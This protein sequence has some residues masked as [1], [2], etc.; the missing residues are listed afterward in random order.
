MGWGDESK[1]TACMQQEEGVSNSCASCFGS[2]IHCTASKCMGK[3]MFGKTPACKACAETNCV[4][5][6]KTCSGITPPSITLQLSATDACTNDA[7][8][9][10]LSSK[11][12][13]GIEADLGACGR[14]SWGDE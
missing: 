6:F 2:L 12:Q 1:A 11:G 4:D 10:A 9:K 8:R 14:S 3:C 13:S 5:G 7:D